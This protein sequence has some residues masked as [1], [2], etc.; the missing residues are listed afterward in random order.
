MNVAGSV[1]NFSQSA[2]VLGVTLD[3]ELSMWPQ[4]NTVIRSCFYQLRQIRA[5]R[6]LLTDSAAVTL[7]V[8]LI[9]SRLD[10]CN[11]I[12]YGSNA[13]VFNKLQ[14]VMNAAARLIT[15]KKRSDH[16]SSVLGDLHWLRARERVSFKIAT[17]VF[18]SLRKTR[19]VYLQE[20]LTPT[21][22]NPRRVSL[23]SATHGD[24]AIPKLRT[25]RLGARSFSSSAPAVWNSLPHTVRAPSLSYGQ[26]ST[27]LK[28]YLFGLSFS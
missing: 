4:V 7:I 17:L 19:P 23:R 22:S 10:Y 24:L 14:S 1:I 3:S 2:K 5:I 20:M 11:S 6:R 28:T 18:D 9:F 8:S 15:G 26:F 27:N 12:Y 21:S 25:H 13:S 16:I